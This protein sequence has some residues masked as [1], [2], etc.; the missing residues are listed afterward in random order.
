VRTGAHNN[1]TAIE[2]YIRICLTTGRP[3]RQATAAET[4]NTS[5][6]GARGWKTRGAPQS[7]VAL[8]EHAESAVGGL[9][10]SPVRSGR[11]GWQQVRRALYIF[12]LGIG[13]PSS[14]GGISYL[15]L[16]L[17]RLH[18]LNHIVACVSYVPPC[19]VGSPLHHEHGATCSATCRGSGSPLQLAAA[20]AAP[21]AVA[22][23][24]PPSPILVVVLPHAPP[25]AAARV[26]AGRDTGLTPA[27]YF[28]GRP[29]PCRGR[30]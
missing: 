4:I 30:L 24:P 11:P 23:S 6:S 28:L 17:I 2:N 9:Y 14:S 16:G 8:A 13:T 25:G 22:V 26:N 21:A 29:G 20:V 5:L 7:A 1:P 19:N 10:S 27:F 12:S 18:T 3:Y 15:C